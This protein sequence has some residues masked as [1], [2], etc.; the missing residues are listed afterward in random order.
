M[1]AKASELSSDKRKALLA[2]IVDAAPLAIIVADAD[3]RI[4]FGSRGAEKLFA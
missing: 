1:C 4:V 2:E 3:G